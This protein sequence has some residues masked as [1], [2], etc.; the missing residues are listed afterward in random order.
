MN[1]HLLEL[2]LNC[3]LTFLVSM[4]LDAVQGSGEA[5]IDTYVGYEER[6]LELLS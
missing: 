3:N 4:G 6:A 5:R 1:P 2:S